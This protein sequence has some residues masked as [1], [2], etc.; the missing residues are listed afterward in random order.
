[1]AWSDEARAAALEARRRKAKQKVP[2]KTNS[3]WSMSMTKPFAFKAS[4]GE[5]ARALR[6]SR[7]VTKSTG[8]NLAFA[9]KQIRSRAIGLALHKIS[10]ASKTMRKRQSAHS[11][12]YAIRQK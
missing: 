6:E 3:F 12:K 1:M 4:R 5:L 11:F 9:H 8:V 7:R 10:S 2:L